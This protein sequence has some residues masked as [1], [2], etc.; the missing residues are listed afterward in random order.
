MNFTILQTEG[1]Q[2]EGKLAGSTVSVTYTSMLYEQPADNQC[3]L[4]LWQNSRI[5]FGL[6]SIVTKQI[7]NNQRIGS[8]SFPIHATNVSYIVGWGA[9]SEA[10][11]SDPNY[12]SIGASLI[13]TPG[14][15]SGGITPG[16]A[17]Q[18]QI[19]PI[20]VS[21]DSV[22]VKF[23]TLPGNTP[24]SNE[25]W[26]GLWLNDTLDFN[27]GYLQKWDVSSSSPEDTQGLE[28]TD[29]I[30]AGTIYTLAYA[31]GNRKSDIVARC[32]FRTADY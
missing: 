25:N 15:G 18:C 24:K 32:T 6:G 31:T 19:Q 8:A 28:V 7:S 29:Q 27:G 4:G 3:F 17:Y 21:Y 10:G 11:K 26:I 14:T 16:V 13:F 20:D 12:K 1:I 30:K 23:T 5:P 9:G 2:L 22:L